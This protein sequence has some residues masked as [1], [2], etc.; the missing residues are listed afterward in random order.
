METGLGM[1]SWRGAFLVWAAA[2]HRFC[3]RSCGPLL[4][5]E[6]TRYKGMKRLDGNPATFADFKTCEFT[7]PEQCVKLSRAD[8]DHFLRAAGADGDH[9]LVIAEAGAV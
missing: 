5:G 3:P 2:S 8:P 7:S 9:S 6:L 4:L 1:A